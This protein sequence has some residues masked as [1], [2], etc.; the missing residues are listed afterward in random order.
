MLKRSQN[1]SAVCLA[2][3]TSAD[4]IFG[5]FAEIV[6]P[7]ALGQA[8]HDLRQLYERSLPRRRS[9]GIHLCCGQRYANC[10]LAY[11][12]GTHQTRDSAQADI[13]YDLMNARGTFTY[14]VGCES[15]ACVHKVVCNI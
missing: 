6:R 7:F 12:S 9:S 1:D 4:L 13:A 10:E 8:L 14:L 2:I 5:W 15:A 3:P 11:V